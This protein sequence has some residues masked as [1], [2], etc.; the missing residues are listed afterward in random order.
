[1]TSTLRES[2]AE[3]QPPIRAL[4]GLNTQGVMVL[5]TTTAIG[6]GLGAVLAQRRILGAFVGGGLGFAL[7]VVST[8]LILLP[9]KRL[10]LA[11][12]EQAK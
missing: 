3:K 6:A 1:M 12:Q 9:L 7:P 2:L 8:L 11:D 10:T 4:V 5:A